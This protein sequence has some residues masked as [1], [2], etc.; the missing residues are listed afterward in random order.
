MRED[1]LAQTA[2]VG[3]AQSM[4]AVYHPLVETHAM[5][6]SA[7]RAM[8]LPMVEIRITGMQH[9]NHAQCNGA[10]LQGEEAGEALA[11]LRAKT[12]VSIAQ[13]PLWHVARLRWRRGNAPRTPAP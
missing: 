10:R 2:L 8:T 1:Q 11:A 3:H 6:S 5:W 9:V 12:T 7:M 13:D 4:V